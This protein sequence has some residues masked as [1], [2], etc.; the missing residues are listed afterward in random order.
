MA[1]L[2]F[3]L[4][5][6]FWIITLLNLPGWPRWAG[7]WY[8]S[9]LHVS[10]DLRLRDRDTEWLGLL[11]R[12]GKLEWCKWRLQRITW[13]FNGEVFQRLKEIE[14]WFKQKGVHQW[15]GLRKGPLIAVARGHLP[16]KIYLS[17]DLLTSEWLRN[18]I[19]PPIG[20]CRY[21]YVH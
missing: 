18:M 21:R 19:R 5:F 3:C 17:L 10:P 16:W 13:P 8:G 14:R 6:K 11:P 15:R 7:G 1:S 20:Y 9:P 2:M 4:P 12:N